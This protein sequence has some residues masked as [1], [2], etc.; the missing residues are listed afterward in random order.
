MSEIEAIKRGLRKRPVREAVESGDLLSTGSTSLNLACSGRVDGGYPLGKYVFFVGDSMSG[1]TWL[2]M[3]AFAEACLNPKLDEYRLIYDDVE[4]GALMDRKRYFGA[5]AAERIE[6]P[7]VGKNGEPICSRTAED[8]HF[9]LDDVLNDGRPFIYVL[10][11][12]DGLTSAAEI[13][14]FGER[15]EAH[16]KG[17]TVAGSYGDAKA[18]VHSANIRKALKPLR[19]MNSLLIVLNQTRDSFDIFER[20]T[21]SGG[22]ALLFYAALQL[23]SSMRGKIMRTVRGKKRELG[24]RCKI[25]VKKNRLIGRDRTVEVP[26]LYST[27]VDDIGGCLDY[28]VGEGQ[29]QKAR[30]GDVEVVGLGPTWKGKRERVIRRIE[31]GGMEEDLKELVLMA[32]QEAERESSVERKKRYN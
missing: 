15:K 32:W 19:E 1:K 13:E 7:R 22:R 30:S 5:K 14:K 11:S 23:W 29:W 28:L 16:R 4:G 24:V 12:Q 31:E 27:G 6:P 3:T 21:Y 10:D 8:F 9:N 26:I 2:G 18:K 25:R 17:R 20:S